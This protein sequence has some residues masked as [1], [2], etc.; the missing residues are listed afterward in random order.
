MHQYQRIWRPSHSGIFEITIGEN[1][2]WQSHLDNIIASKH[3][4]N[5]LM[6]GHNG[7]PWAAVKNVT[8]DHVEEVIQ[9]AVCNDTE[10][11]RKGLKIGETKYMALIMDE[12]YY[13]F[14]NGMI[15]LS[16]YLSLLLLICCFVVSSLPFFV[17][18]L[19]PS[20]LCH[21]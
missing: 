6:F 19:D 13:Q 18:C 14:I 16:L 7:A 4:D 10:Y 20:F 2:S 21:L 1:M 17:G 9:A 3:A 5:A 12:P 11:L 15:A 8:I